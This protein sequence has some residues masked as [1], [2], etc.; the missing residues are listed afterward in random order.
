[1]PRIGIIGEILGGLT[2]QPFLFDVNRC[3]GF[4]FKEE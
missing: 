1:M 3:A 2:D 4:D